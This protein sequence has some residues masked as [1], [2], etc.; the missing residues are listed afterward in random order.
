MTLIIILYVIENTQNRTGTF[1]LKER[2]STD[3]VLF[4]LK[5]SPPLLKSSC[6]F[7]PSLSPFLTLRKGQERGKDKSE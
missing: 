5:I 3:Q 7:N 4:P 2:H 6:P 1:S